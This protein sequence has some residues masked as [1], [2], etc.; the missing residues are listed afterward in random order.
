MESE[1]DV[2]QHIQIAAVHHQCF[3]MRNNSGALK[4]ATG[5]WVFYGLGN[6]SKKHG[7]HIKS[8]DLIGF[9]IRN[10]DAIFTAVEVKPPGWKYSDRD[11]RATAQ[12]AFINWVKSKGGIA[13]FCTSVDDFTELMHWHV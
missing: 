11:K 5:R 12:L 4:D 6:I 2:Q 7:E 10:G 13:G 8:S 9:T 1:S 3:L